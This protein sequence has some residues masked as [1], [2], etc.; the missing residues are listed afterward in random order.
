MLFAL[1]DHRLFTQD[2]ELNTSTNAYKSVIETY[3]II[4]YVENTFKEAW[5]THLTTY[6][7][8]YYTYPLSNYIGKLACDK[9]LGIDVMDKESWNTVKEKMMRPGGTVIPREYLCGFIGD[10]SLLDF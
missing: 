4:P 10:L 8:S 2:P 7:A 3:G 9:L 1:F 5:S 6:G